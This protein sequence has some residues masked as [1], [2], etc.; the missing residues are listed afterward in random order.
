MNLN[1]V[2]KLSQKHRAINTMVIFLVLTSLLIGGL[3]FPLHNKIKSTSDI[4]I[5]ER[6]SIV[7]KQSRERN[8]VGLTKE[9]E[10][11]EPNIEN[12]DLVFINEEN[13]LDFI[14]AIENIATINEVFQKLEIVPPEK[15]SKDKY[16]KVPMTLTA[17]GELQS[18]YKYLKDLESFSYQLNIEKIDINSKGTNSED[19]KEVSLKLQVN[20]YWKDHESKT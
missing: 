14:T 11:I 4:V 17:Q 1:K 15:L 2:K 13:Q 10:E 16:L 19:K 3:M 18:I 12:F 6:A 9:L 8:I 7:E 5:K 20:T